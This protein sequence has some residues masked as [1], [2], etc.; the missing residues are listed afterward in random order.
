MMYTVTWWRYPHG[1][2]GEEMDCKSK[3][4]NNLEK[5]IAFANAKAERIRGLYWAGCW[6]EDEVHSKPVYEITDGYE[7]FRNYE[8]NQVCS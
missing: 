1:I 3:D 6:V 2:E 5:A 8:S 7:I 4:F